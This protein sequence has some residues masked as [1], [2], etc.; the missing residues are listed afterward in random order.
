MYEYTS[1]MKIVKKQKKVTFKTGRSF[2]AAMSQEVGGMDQRW[3]YNFMIHVLLSIIT[4]LVI[5]V[6]FLFYK[7]WLAEDM[8]RELNRDYEELAR[9]QSADSGGELKKSEKF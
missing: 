6:L 2:Q 9:E 5:S 8:I 4:V 3:K 1:I 7:N